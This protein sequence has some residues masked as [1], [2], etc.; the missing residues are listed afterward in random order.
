MRYATINNIPFPDL[1][2]MSQGRLECTITD[3]DF[4][5]SLA[6]K[7]CFL[8]PPWVMRASPAGGLAKITRVTY[9]LDGE[10]DKPAILVAVARKLADLG[11]MRGRR[12]RI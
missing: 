8:V 5:E 1:V 11:R 9:T 12:F 7:H 10:M 4:L 2:A 6:A 3:L